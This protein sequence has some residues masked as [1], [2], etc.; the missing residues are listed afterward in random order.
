M[1]WLAMLCILSTLV[2]WGDITQRRIKNHDVVI[3]MVLGLAINISEYSSLVF[4]LTEAIAAG[5]LALV[6]LLPFYAKG[7][8]GAADVKLAAALGIWLGFELL[9]P[10][11]ILSVLMAI[12]YAKMASWDLLKRWLL[13][14]EVRAVSSLYHR[15]FVPYGAMLCLSAILVGA[16]RII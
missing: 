3:L 5:C 2:I 12:V 13:P 9:F 7:W 14:A 1:A 11:W 16:Q 15:K 8:M 10:V 6:A 4:S